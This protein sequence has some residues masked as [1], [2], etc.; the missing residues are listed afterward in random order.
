M[1]IFIFI[2]DTLDFDKILIMK[3]VLYISKQIKLDRYYLKIFT[4]LPTGISYV[5]VAF[6]APNSPEAENSE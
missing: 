3:Q 4:P 6:K 1:F 5:G 2:T